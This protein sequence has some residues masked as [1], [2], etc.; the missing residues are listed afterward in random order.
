[1][2]DSAAARGQQTNLM[3]H[4]DSTAWKPDANRLRTAGAAR[5]PSTTQPQT[6][7]AASTTRTGAAP[8]APPM[9]TASTASRTAAAVGTTSHSMS[10]SAALPRSGVSPTYNANRWQMASV[11]GAHSTWQNG[12][13]TRTWTGV[14]P[15]SPS[16]N[17]R[18]FGSAPNFSRYSTSPTF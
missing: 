13:P 15:S 9:S 8:A 16:A 18:T 12:A 1:A 17:Y 14:S 2:S 10:S 3:P 4:T 11:N 7:T 6:S 5:S